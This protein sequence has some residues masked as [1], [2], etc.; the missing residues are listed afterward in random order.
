M[1]VV[2]SRSRDLCI[3]SSNFFPSRSSSEVG[4]AE[5]DFFGF[6][7]ASRSVFAAA[8]AGGSA[9]ITRTRGRHGALSVVIALARAAGT[10]PTWYPGTSPAAMI[11][12][13]NS[14]ALSAFAAV[15]DFSASPWEQPVTRANDSALTATAAH[16]RTPDD[17]FMGELCA[18]RQRIVKEN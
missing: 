17:L 9:L 3:V 8:S 14:A 5:G 13:F 18:G 16:S 1:T 12:F 10:G 11:R 6:S 4:L 15:P 2:T 7:I